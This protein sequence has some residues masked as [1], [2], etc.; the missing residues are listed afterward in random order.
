MIR[1]DLVEHRHRMLGRAWRAFR[2]DP[3][4]FGPWLLDRAQKLAECD[5][6]TVFQNVRLDAVAPAHRLAANASRRAE[7]PAKRVELPAGPG[8]TFFAELGEGSR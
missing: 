2:A 8:D 4:R 1:R 3:E 6:S 7:T 5:P